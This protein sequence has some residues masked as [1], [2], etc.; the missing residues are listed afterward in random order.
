MDVCADFFNHFYHQISLKNAQKCVK[1]KGMVWAG[2]LYHLCQ[3]KILKHVQKYLKLKILFVLRLCWFL[4]SYLSPKN[5][6]MLTNIQNSKESFVLRLS[7]LLRSFLSPNNSGQAFMS[8]MFCSSAR[9]KHEKKH[10][11]GAVVCMWKELAY[12]SWIKACE[13]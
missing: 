2:F 1:P 7:W 12:T 11:G 8:F 13:N 3:P 9:Q 10:G 4:Q 6:K 5:W